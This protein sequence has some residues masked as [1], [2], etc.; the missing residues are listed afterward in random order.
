MVEEMKPLVSL[1]AYPQ[2]Q[3]EMDHSHVGHV[4][5]RWNL[6]S[7]SLIEMISEYH[8]LT[9]EHTIDIINLCQSR[10]NT[11]TT[12]IHLLA[13][14]LDSEYRGLQP[15]INEWSLII[16]F[17]HQYEN[18]TLH[19]GEAHIQIT[20]FLIRTEQFVIFH[21][22]WN[23]ADRPL[24]FWTETCLESPEL[25][26]LA[27]HIFNTPANS[28]PSER[29]FSTQNIVHNK[30]QSNLSSMQTNMLAYIHINKRILES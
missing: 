24:A 15:S 27:V 30:T 29:A 25:G 10:K 16:N 12:T 19:T 5:K 3:S 4:L 21:P 22:V 8:T 6:I 18:S 2:K 7:N 1:I 14:F 17:L 9:S 11:Q 26:E 28:V 13:Y 20:N 23:L